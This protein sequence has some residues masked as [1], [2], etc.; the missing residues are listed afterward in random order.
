[1]FRSLLVLV[2]V[3]LAADAKKLASYIKPCK[4]DD[5]NLNECAKKNGLEA[6]PFLLK[7]DKEYKNPS[8]SPLLLPRL[9]VDAGANLKITFTDVTLRGLETVDFR[10]IKINLDK[11]TIFVQVA[12][13]ALN[14]QGHYE[15]DGRI[16]VLPIQGNGPCNLTFEDLVVNYGFKYELVKKED[17]KNYINP[18]IKPDV[19]YTMKNVHFQF[20][21]LFNGD[22]TL[23]DQ[24]NKFLNE[25]SGDINKDL[26]ESI[27]QTISAVVTNI[28]QLIVAVVPYDEIFI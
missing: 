15:I 6:I 16:L 23:G 25:N 26:G 13:K 18:N 2:V 20:D 1:M 3:A 17:G 14:L 4:R 8:L 28:I 24:T 12:L 5:P 21:N 9:D 10:D 11:K 22:K 19:T 27:S 7:G